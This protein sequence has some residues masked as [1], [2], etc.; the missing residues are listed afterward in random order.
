[1]LLRPSIFL[2]SALFIAS[3]RYIEATKYVYAKYDPHIQSVQKG[4]ELCDYSTEV[5]FPCFESGYFSAYCIFSKAAKG[6]GYT[7][8]SAIQLKF[9]ANDAKTI[10]TY[11]LTD[12]NVPLK[13]SF[14]SGNTFLYDQY[15]NDWL[16]FEFNNDNDI[17]IWD[18]NTRTL[19]EIKLKGPGFHLDVNFFV[20]FVIFTIL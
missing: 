3:F 17:K 6:V 19:V 16:K 14:D 1:M 10:E 4:Y 13:S 9:T 11:T 15:G 8:V 2:V 18:E 7:Y 20:Y 5:W 12:V